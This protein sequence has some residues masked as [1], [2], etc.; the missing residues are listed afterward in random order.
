MSG[1]GC[2]R[3]GPPRGEEGFVEVN[4]KRGSSQRGLLWVCGAGPRSSAALPGC[5][6]VVGIACPTQPRGRRSSASPLRR[7][8]G[9]EVCPQA[10]GCDA[11]LSPSPP[12]SRCC[13]SQRRQGG[14]DSALCDRAAHGAAP[15]AVP[16]RRPSAFCG[17]VRRC[18][19]P[20][21]RF[22]IAPFV[23]SVLSA[24]FSSCPAK[25]ALQQPIWLEYLHNAKLSCEM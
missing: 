25:S 19:A 18:E 8:R 23:N 10:G 4:V 20:R 1:R 5:P 16:Q 17:A 7:R 9:P 12:H 13:P 21:E 3:V 14:G 22:P 24:R 11:E 15:R 2:R 6:V